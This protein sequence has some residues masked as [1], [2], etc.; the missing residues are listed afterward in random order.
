VVESP[1]RVRVAIVGLGTVG[2]WLLRAIEHRRDRLRDRHGF[3][4]SVVALATRRAGFV[5]RPDGIDIGEALSARDAGKALATVADT[6]TWPTALEGVQSTDA[7]LLVEVSQSP[8]ADG[9]PGASHLREALGRGISVATSNKWPIALRGVEL[10]RL[11]ERHGAD[12]RAESTVMSG[13]PVLAALTEGL[14]GA[15]PLRLRGVLNATVNHI[16]SR[17][18]AGIAY[19]DA[20]AE[21]ERLGLAEPDPS[22]DVDGF[23]SAAK[24][25]VLSAL[26][27][28]DQLE[29]EDVERRGVSALADGELEA[30]RAGGRRIREVATLDASTGRASV[31]A[32]PIGPE[33]PLY[34]IEGTSNVVHL[35]ADPLGW[36][37][38][39]GPGAGPELA[40]QGVLADLIAL[41][42]RHV[43]LARHD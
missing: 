37:S 4:L 2:G 29:L 6:R 12:L 42:R 30:A 13:T 19:A 22:A 28:G 27:F 34:S 8:A 17:L 10:I 31:E 20:L 33:D 11:A 39:T 9:E 32:I 21:A 16:C 24:L 35:E 15:T 36:I 1:A 23:D 7:D 14:G 41:G 40:G 25:M 26:V 3:E 43:A 5:H 18:D 38:I